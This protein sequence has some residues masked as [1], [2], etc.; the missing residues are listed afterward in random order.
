MPRELVEQKLRAITADM[1]DDR[2]ERFQP[3]GGFLRIG[4]FRLRTLRALEYPKTAT[5]CYRWTNP[6]WHHSRIDAFGSKSSE[7]MVT[8]CSQNERLICL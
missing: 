6:S 3:F 1:R 5:A 2:I 4:I 7:S 8:T